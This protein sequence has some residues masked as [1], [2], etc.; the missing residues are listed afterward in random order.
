M[1]N[2]IN[3]DLKEAYLLARADGWR[4][5]SIAWRAPMRE[6]KTKELPIG[7]PIGELSHDEFFGIE[8]RPTQRQ[9]V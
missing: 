7:I 5:L 6:E 2:K 9:R 8:D 3:R 1:P 4:Y